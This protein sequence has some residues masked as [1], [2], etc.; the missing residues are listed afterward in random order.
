MAAKIEVKL[1]LLEKPKGEFKCIEQYAIPRGGEPL[2]HVCIT[3][4][5][6][7][8][9]DVVA[10]DPKLLKEVSRLEKELYNIIVGDESL[11]ERIGKIKDPKLRHVVERQFTGYGFLEPFFM[12]PDIVNVHVMVGR[13]AQVLH[14]FYGRL[15]TN[16]AFS[17]EEAKEL[18]MRLAAAAGKPLSEAL[19]LASFIEPRYEAR[20]SLVYM[21]DVTMRRDMTIDIRKLPENPW[22]I[23]KLIHFGTLSIEE[24]AF[25]WLMVKYKVPI[26]IVGEL[27]SGKTTVAAA[28]MALVPPESRVLTAEDTPE[29]RIPAKYWTRTTTREFGEYKITYFDLIKTGV[30]LSVDYVIV[31]EIRGEEAREWAHAILLG[32][33]AVCLPGDQLVLMMVDGKV[34]LYEVGAVVSGVQVGKY[35]SVKVIALNREGRPEWVEVSGTVVKNGSNRFVRITSTGGVVHEVHE[36]HLVV[37]YKNNG[38]ACKKAKELEPGD[39]LV[40][41]KYLPPIPSGS[42][43]TSIDVFSVLKKYVN[44]LYVHG[45]SGPLKKVGAPR[46]SKVAGVPYHRAYSWLRGSA[47]PAAKALELV[48]VNVV[49]REDL[50]GSAV[51]FGTRGKC[52]LPYRIPLSRRLGY[53]IGLFLARGTMRYDPGDGLPNEIVFRA[54]IGE[55]SARRITRSLEEV[56][57]RREAVR[58]EKTS[59]ARGLKVVVGSKIFATLVYEV[60]EGRTRYGERSI[61]L[62]LALRAPE[63]FREGLIKGFWEG[64]GLVLRD[65]KG[66]FRTIAKAPNRKLAESLVVVLRS[67]GIDAGVKVAS[68]G[69]GLNGRGNRAT[70]VI[71]ITRGKERFLRVMGVRGKSSDHSKV[72]DNGNY[73][74]YPVEKIEVV[75]KDS[76]LYDVEVPAPHMYTISGGLIVTH[77]TTFHAE[78]PEAAL[79]RLVSPPIS[80]DPQV[81]KLLNVFVKTNVFERGGKRTFRH[82]VHIVEENITVPLFIYD[83]K[84]DKI[85]MNT[86]IENPIRAFRFIDRIVLAH[87][88]PKEV[89]EREYQAM[90]ET[91]KETYREALEKDPT[92]ETPTY[93]ELP[94]ILYRR[95]EG[96]LRSYTHA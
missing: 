37:I 54:K 1:R 64:C 39:L 69:K 70:Y 43:L 65:G 42:A 52:K 38:L 23:L 91:I 56:G 33:G 28:L 16:L 96:K 67:L 68:S 29:F 34:D 21:S 77:N 17:S 85:V 53:L 36:D 31:G 41:V 94:E 82:E 40:A 2:Y 93:K 76:A 6:Y 14:R 92:L 5:T 74:L 66:R 79:L 80:V 45:L 58:I 63:G 86:Q 19:P 8:V 3:N 13:P 20:V 73:L 75:E 12:D 24:A 9:Y 50:E 18:A 84:T 78:S 87:R 44:R 81:L 62:D 26:I 11:V 25:L 22:T 83:P 72:T 30:R 10:A 88:V 49:S 95:L 59:S 27:M 46:I 15:Y 90:V 7:I 71:R 61:P 60:L 57:V 4:D 51:T 48:K 35:R 55:N 89:L 32:H 47:V